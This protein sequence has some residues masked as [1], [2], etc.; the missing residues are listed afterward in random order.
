[1]SGYLA[2]P[3]DGR[4]QHKKLQFRNVAA[5]LWPENRALALR[6]WAIL[7]PQLLNEVMLIIDIPKLN[8]EIGQVRL[9]STRYSIQ[10]VFWTT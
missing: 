7:A 9:D 6:K 2:P 1:M 3:L 8:S 5:M 4:D 10:R